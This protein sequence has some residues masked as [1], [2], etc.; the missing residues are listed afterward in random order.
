M[1]TDSP[2]TKQIPVERL[3]DGQSGKLKGLTIDK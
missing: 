3:A 2:G 1:R